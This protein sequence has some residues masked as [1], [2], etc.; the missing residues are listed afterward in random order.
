[1][2]SR[3][4]C[5]LRSLGYIIYDLGNARRLLHLLRALNFHCL[6]KNKIIPRAII[7]SIEIAKLISTISAKLQ[8]DVAQNKKNDLNTLA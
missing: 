7:S 4:Y 8:I 2:T 3:T 6:K 5:S 1:M